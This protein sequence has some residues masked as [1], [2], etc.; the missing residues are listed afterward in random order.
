MSHNDDVGRLIRGDH[1]IVTVYRGFLGVVYLCRQDLPQGNHVYKAIKTFRRSKEIAS[2]GLFAR[3]LA[4]WVALPPH[5]NLVQ[6][7]D[8]DTVNEQLALEFVPGPNLHSVAR[9]GPIHPRHFL[10]WANQIAA[11]LHFLHVDN[12]FVHRGL[13][14]ENILFDT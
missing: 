4:Y 12:H 14:P 6:A 11:G 2:R 1:R 9:R 8:A 10:R 7:K 13:R 3:E 5:P